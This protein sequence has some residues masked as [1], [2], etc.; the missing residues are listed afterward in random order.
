V[1]SE[2]RCIIC[3][4]PR[5]A[6]DCTVFELTA[7][8]ETR[9]ISKGI[10]PESEYVYCEPCFGVICDASAAPRFMRSVFERGLLEIGVEPKRAKAIAERYQ[11]RI[12]EMQRF[13]KHSTQS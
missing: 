6:E 3:G 13:V 2:K 9:M 8:E 7:A 11:Q 4:R 1:T 12:V 5:P 10:T